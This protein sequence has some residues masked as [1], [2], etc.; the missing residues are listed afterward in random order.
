[1]G[2]LQLYHLNS[3]MLINWNQVEEAI[4]IHEGA[5]L[6]E[7]ADYERQKARA[8]QGGPHRGSQQP[9]GR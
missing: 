3:T 7:K 1:M 4:T 2:E 5:R 6:A 9:Q 8:Q